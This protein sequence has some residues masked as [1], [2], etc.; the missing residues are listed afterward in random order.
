MTQNDLV[1]ALCNYLFNTT[2]RVGWMATQ[3]QRA[4]IKA[5]LEEWRSEINFTKDDEDEQ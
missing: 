4:L 5:Q 1:D 3:D 2:R